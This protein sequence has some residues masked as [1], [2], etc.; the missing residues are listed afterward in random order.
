MKINIGPAFIARPPTRLKA[1]LNKK[2]ELILP[3]FSAISP[4]KEVHTLAADLAKHA[5]P[6]FIR[7]LRV[8]SEDVLRNQDRV[9]F[10]VVSKHLTQLHAIMLSKRVVAR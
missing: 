1:R 2:N 6:G 4:S 8:S 5:N 3:G 7:I 9:P 10:D